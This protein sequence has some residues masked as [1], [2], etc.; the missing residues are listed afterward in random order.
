MLTTN[1]KP[2][3][4]MQ[5]KR[6]RIQESIKEIQQIMRDETKRRK[7]TENYKNNCKTSNRM[8]ITTYLTIITLNVNG[9]NAPI[10]RHRVTEWIEKQ[11]RIRENLQEQPQNK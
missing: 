5:K 4:D 11:E 6:E 2:V 1:L 10:K 8:A 3:I 9:L 7:R